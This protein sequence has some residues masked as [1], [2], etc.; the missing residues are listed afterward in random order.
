MARPP[1]NHQIRIN[2][3]LDAAE[4]L[5]GSHGYHQT[6]IDDIV[7]EIGMSH[8]AFYYYFS[9]KEDIIEHLIDRH[10][11]RFESEVAA[12]ACS[13]EIT[14]P[15]K[16]I[17]IV[18]TIFDSVQYKKDLLLEFLY[19]DRYMHLLDKI[20]S[21]FNKMLTPYLLDI[22]EEGNRKKYFNALY[23]LESMQFVTAVFHCFMVAIYEKKSAN[24]LLHLFDIGKSLVEKILGLQDGTLQTSEQITATIKKITG[25]R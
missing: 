15:Q 12:I 11:S 3:I 1:K 10:L 21:R 13:A 7:R 6:M 17:L 23:P 4:A 19:D 18:K 24:V 25:R 14:P 9:S 2:E 22:I 5:F 16:I 8:G 20:R